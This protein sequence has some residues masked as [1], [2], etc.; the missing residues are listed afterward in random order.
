LLDENLFPELTS[1]LSVSEVGPAVMPQYLFSR[2]K[3]FEILD[4]SDESL[5]ANFELSLLM[6]LFDC[7]ISVVA[8]GKDIFR[9]LM[10]F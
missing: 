7:D 1:S 8:I 9:H 6:F 5:K 10:E 4:G 3:F 2:N